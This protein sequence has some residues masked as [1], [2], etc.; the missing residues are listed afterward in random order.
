MKILIY[1]EVGGKIAVL[2]DGGKVVIA[3]KESEMA[4]YNLGIG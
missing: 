4:E 1:N 3:M 2:M